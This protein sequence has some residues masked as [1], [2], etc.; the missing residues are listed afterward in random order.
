LCG[1]LPC[2]AKY[3]FCSALLF[4]ART[5]SSCTNENIL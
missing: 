3:Q 1:I 2:A 4:V 5:K